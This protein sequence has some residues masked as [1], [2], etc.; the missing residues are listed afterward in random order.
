MKHRCFHH[1]LF[2]AAALVTVCALVSGAPQSSKKGGGAKKVE[3]AHPFYWAPPDALRGDW[4][5]EGGYVAQVIRADDR[6][7]SVNDQLPDANDGGRYE[8]HVF[9]KFDQ[10]NDKPVAILKGEQSGEAVEFTGDGWAGS[11][12]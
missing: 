8:A 5:G 6:L 11:I 3:L 9:H 4:Q 10:P 1:S 12:A 2:A 7:L